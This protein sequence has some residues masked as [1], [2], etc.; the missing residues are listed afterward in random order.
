MTIKLK[1]LLKE[2]ALGEM[3]SDKLMKM[4]WN[5]VTEAE[6]FDSSGDEEEAPGSNSA[7]KKFDSLLKGKPAWEKIKDLITKLSD[8]KQA[9]FIEY[10]MKDASVSDAAK[11]KLKLKL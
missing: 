9:E 4:K 11:S 6:V 5:P 3:P 8:S 7:V 2:S 10:M 1:D